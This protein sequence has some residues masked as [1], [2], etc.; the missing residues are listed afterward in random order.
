MTPRQS[1]VARALLDW[2]RPELVKKLGGKVSQ[3]TIDNF[4]AG[5]GD[6]LPATVEA[7]QRVYAA[8]GITFDP[9]GVNVRLAVEGRGRRG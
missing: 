4:E 1:I 2:S 9:D 5:R 6:P 8:A 7:L 3:R